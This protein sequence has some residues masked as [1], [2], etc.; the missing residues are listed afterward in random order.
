MENYKQQLLNE[1]SKREEKLVKK[2]QLEVF[3]NLIEKVKD[4][5]DDELNRQIEYLLTT[6]S[7]FEVMPR[8]YE[9][10]YKRGFSAL[11]SYVRKTFGYVAKGTIAGE[12][13]ALGVGIGIVFG[14]LL[15]GVNAGFIGIGLAL[16]AGLGIA[17]GQS[18]E[19]EEEK[20]GNTY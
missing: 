18:K 2:Y 10:F 7:K 17:T 20:N 11:K 14:A 3:M 12:H 19:K 4:K 5:E 1:I 16:G 15:S 8:T 13:M 6:L 9:R